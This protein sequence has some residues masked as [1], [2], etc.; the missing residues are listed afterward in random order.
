MLADSVPIMQH[1]FEAKQKVNRRKKVKQVRG[2]LKRKIHLRECIPD[3]G[4]IHE[5]TVSDIAS[6]SIG[7]GTGKFFNQGNYREAI[8]YYVYKKFIILP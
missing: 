3:Q 1:V 4:C 8:S 5:L 2:I 6:T 7:K